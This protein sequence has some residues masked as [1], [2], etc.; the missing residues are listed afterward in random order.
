MRRLA[1]VNILVI[2]EFDSIKELIRSAFKKM[3]ETVTVAVSGDNELG[4]LGSKFCLNF[5]SSLPD[6]IIYDIDSIKKEALWK[7]ERML[8][9]FL[10]IQK[11][12]RHTPS[13]I[14]AS[15]FYQLHIL[16]KN[17]HFIEDYVIIK[18]FTFKQVIQ[19]VNNV[20][21]CN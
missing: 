5:H 2:S 9:T 11:N 1:K 7:V 12:Q 17:I 3:S 20:S 10:W 15:S 13:L 18:P 16:Q 14:I 21:N 4:T 19:V 6:I 8:N